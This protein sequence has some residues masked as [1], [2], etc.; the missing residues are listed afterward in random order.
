M[1]QNEIPADLFI[2]LINSAGIDYILNE[3]EDF[4]QY[5]PFTIP[6]KIMLYWSHPAGLVD[7]LDKLIYCVGTDR[8]RCRQQPLSRRGWGLKMI[9]QQSSKLWTN[10]ILWDLSL[11][12]ITDRYP[13]LQQPLVSFLKSNKVSRALTHRVYVMGRNIQ[14]KAQG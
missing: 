3:H 4:D 5:G 8:C 6:S 7:S 2:V 12:G 11:S 9:K 1:N 13:I 10:D 14:M